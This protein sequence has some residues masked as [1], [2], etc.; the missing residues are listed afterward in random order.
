MRSLRLPLRAIC[1]ASA[2]STALAATGGTFEEGG[3]TLVSAM[4]MFLGNDQSVYI[5]DKA[6]GNAAQ[7]LGHPAW[8]SVWD[9]KTRRAVVMDIKTNSFCASGMHLPNGS[10]V[11]FGGNDAVGQNG[12]AG[13]QKNPDGTGA[14][15]SYYQDF[16]GRRAIRI[17]TPCTITDTLNSGPC[18]WYDEPT[19]LSLRRERWY[20]AA[21]ATGEGE[22]VIIGG[23]VRGG[24]VNRW[25]PN[26]DPATSDGQADPTYE[27]YPPR[28]GEPRTFDFLIKTSG[29]NSYA[30][31]YLMP[32][33]R[34]LVQANLSTTLWDH[35]TNVETPLPPMPKGVVRVYPASGATTML[36]LTVANK[37][38]PTLLFCGG[39]DMPEADYAPH[40]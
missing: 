17:V 26:V 8:G 19:Q 28:S 27:Y 30:H 23:F 3:S 14:W 36:P 16:D 5:L 11:T 1:I 2:I 39:S 32:S 35:N 25:V 21:E 38:T 24:F 37:Y 7:V 29:L 6:E 12:V 20:S 34:I 13:S 9:I 4:M 40:P 18:A 33:G 10:Y 15:D 22:V 31:T